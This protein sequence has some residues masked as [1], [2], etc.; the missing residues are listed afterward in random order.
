MGKTRRKGTRRNKNKKN[1]I[2]NNFKLFYKLTSNSKYKKTK[3]KPHR[4]GSEHVNGFSHSDIQLFKQLTRLH[5]PASQEERATQFILD[6][7]RNNKKSWKVKPRVLHGG[8]FQNNIVLV[9]GKP[10][11]ALFAHLDN[12]GFTVGHNKQL[13]PIGGVELIKNAKLRGF[14][15]NDK[16]VSTKLLYN[17]RKIYHAKKDIIE[18]GTNLT[19]LPEWKVKNNQITS[20]N[21]DDKF[22]VFMGL[23]LAK[24]LKNG[25]IVFSAGEEVDGGNIPFLIKYIH[26]KYKIKNTLVLDVTMEEHNLKMGIGPAVAIR[27]EDIFDRKFIQRVIDTLKKEKATFQ[28]A[29][30]DEGSSDGKAIAHSPFPI[31]TAF[32]GAC[33]KNIHTPF[34]VIHKNDFLHTLN[35]LNIL[36]KK[37]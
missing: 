9:F 21:I 23:H 29:V 17:S 20:G 6:F 12:V 13:F 11:L 36:F 18:L 4:K 24:N 5:S 30:G 16:P 28:I 19:Y 27:D 2:S 25:I 15:N 14:D 37:L 31:N 26:E 22:G 33:I 3:K 10:K 32:M 7:I 1:R 35:C 8:D 34:E